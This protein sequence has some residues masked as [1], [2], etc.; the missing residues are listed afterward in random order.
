MGEK[1]GQRLR[2]FSTP[3]FGVLPAD[4]VEASVVGL[5][6][7]AILP[8]LVREGTPRL[9][10]IVPEFLAQVVQVLVISD[11]VGGPVGVVVGPAI[12]RFVLGGWDGDVLC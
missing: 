9:V 4:V 5:P 1:V 10:S 7:G 2:Y 3:D 12:V 6:L 8:H 11:D